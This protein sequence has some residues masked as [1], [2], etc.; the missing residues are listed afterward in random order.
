MVAF[1]NQAVAASQAVSHEPGNCAGISA[2][3]YKGCAVADDEPYGV[4]G[5][6]GNGEGVDGQILEGKSAAAFEF[7]ADENVFQKFLAGTEGKRV[8][9]DGNFESPRKN[10]DAPDMVAV[11]MGHEYPG[12][13]LRFDSYLR[14]AV[15]QLFPG[16]PGIYQNPGGACLDKRG[17]APAAAAQNT[18]THHFFNCK[19]SILNWKTMQGAGGF[20]HLLPSAFSLLPFDFQL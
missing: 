6:M 18:E 5:I 4:G 10:R 14:Q 15:L 20:F 7:S 9:K 11:L 1:E 3:A 17:I 19:F 2:L 13:A 16:E 12:Q 8:Y